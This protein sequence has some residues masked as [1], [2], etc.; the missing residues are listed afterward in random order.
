MMEIKR[1]PDRHNSIQSASA[2]LGEQILDLVSLEAEL[3][4]GLI[5]W[6]HKGCNIAKRADVALHHHASPHHVP[7]KIDRFRKRYDSEL[8]RQSMHGLDRPV[9][10]ETI[11]IGQLCN[12]CW[13]IHRVA[14]RRY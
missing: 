2:R 10:G 5:L 3:N 6:R 4:K 8:V 11:S 1:A 13:R 7:A 9:E 14:S 12:R